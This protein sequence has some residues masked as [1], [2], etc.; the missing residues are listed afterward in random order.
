MRGLRKRAEKIVAGDRAIDSFF[1]DEDDEQMEIDIE[2]A[3]RDV[4]RETAE[5]CAELI[6]D[7]DPGLADMIRERFHLKEKP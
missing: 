4:Q 3:L 7:C 2:Q 6:H 5:E 1:K